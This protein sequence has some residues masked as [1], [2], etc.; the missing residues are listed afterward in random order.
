MIF[1]YFLSKKIIWKLVNA[2]AISGLKNNSTE[3]SDHQQKV[4]RDIRN[5]G[6]AVTHLDTFDRKALSNINEYYDSLTPIESD[7]K[8]FL[9]YYLGGQYKHKKQEFSE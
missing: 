8:S 2:K 5:E 3:L 1:G 9:T 4:L 7:V 6:Y